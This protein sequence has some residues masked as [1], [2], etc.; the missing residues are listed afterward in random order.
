M[1]DVTTGTAKQFHQDS[2]LFAPLVS[3]HFN[4]KILVRACIIIHQQKNQLYD[5]KKYQGLTIWSIEVMEQRSTA[6]PQ[7]DTD[8]SKKVT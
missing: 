2:L 7:I 4:R 6:P 3:K 8:S 1:L 5:G